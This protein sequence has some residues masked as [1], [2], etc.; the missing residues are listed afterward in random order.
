MTEPPPPAGVNEVLAL[1]RTRNYLRLLVLVAILGAPIAAAAY[2]FL[3]LVADL[4]KWLYN[5]AYL[6]KA[7]GFHGEPIWWPLPLL[8]LA[9]VLV[10]LT[11]RYLPGRGGHSPAD[12]FQMGQPPSPVQLPGVALA[13][14]AG[15]ALGAVIGPEAPLI[16]LGSGLAVAAVR[17][18][19]HNA[20]PQSLRVIGAAGSFSAIA[21]LFGSPLSAAFLLMEA[22]GLGGPLLGLVLVPGLLAA[23]IG[24]LIFVGFDDWT[25]HGVVSLTVPNL[26]AIS[27][28]DGAEVGW[29]IAIGVA[30]AL[31]GAGIRWLGLY[32][33]PHV[34]QRITL[35]APVV[36]L[37]VAGLAIAYAEG[38]GKSSSDVLFSGQSAL[39]S[40]LTNNASYSIGALMLLLVCKGLAYG[41]SL[42]GFRG[43]PTFPAMFIGAVGGVAVSHLPGLPALVGAG[44]GIGAMTCAMLGLPLSSVLI[45]T[46]FLGSDGVKMMPV[47]I[48]AVVVTYV[49]RAY[50][51]P[52]PRSDPQAMSGPAPVPAAASVAQSVETEH[53]DT[54]SNPAR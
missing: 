46:I 7:L 50:L 45:T 28:P 44:M 53:S 31:L 5:P 26:P 24:S 17:A 48:V 51:L 11:I 33:K 19:R 9:G 29:A 4:Q 37:V 20:P 40:F 21:T 30:A 36:G 49:V 35:L 38:S 34:E 15:L 41:V 13:A 25:G 10:G 14:L 6:L 42:S 22:S 32:L 16:A 39:P 47:V 18:V 12:G 2:W 3:Y 27:P 43:G 54:R 1:L 23:G 52:Q 8:G